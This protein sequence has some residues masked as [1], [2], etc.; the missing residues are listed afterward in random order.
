MQY[1]IY[2]QKLHR[3][4]HMET[5]PTEA[6]SDVAMKKFGYLKW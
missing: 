5:M 1:Q 6:K 3:Y 2:Y 4:L